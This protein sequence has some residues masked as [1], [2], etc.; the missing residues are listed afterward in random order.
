VTTT[1]VALRPL[2]PV[3]ARA[4]IPV[5]EFRFR[6]TTAAILGIVLYVL[7]AVGAGLALLSWSHLGAFAS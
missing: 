3:L 2:L 7:L 1:Y 6:R 5:R 4:P